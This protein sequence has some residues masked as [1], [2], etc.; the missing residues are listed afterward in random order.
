MVSEVPLPSNA[1]ELVFL[2]DE[3]FVESFVNENARFHQV[4]Q[5]L[6]PSRTFNTTLVY[7]AA[8]MNVIES[9]AYR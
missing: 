5:S 7:H 8:P 1:C 3:R 4:M 9:V 6:V 2:P